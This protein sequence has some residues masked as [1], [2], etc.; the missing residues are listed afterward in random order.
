MKEII[1]KILRKWAD[2][3]SPIDETIPDIPSPCLRNSALPKIVKSQYKYPKATTMMNFDLIRRDIA[4]KMADALLQ[5]G[6]I[7][8]SVHEGPGPFN[9]IEGTMFVYPLE[10]QQP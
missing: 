6:A 3:L 5:H 9:T 7:H 4:G 10:E 2:K 8:F 1:A